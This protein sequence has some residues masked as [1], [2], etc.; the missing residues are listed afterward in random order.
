MLQFILSTL[1]IWVYS[2]TDSV[3][4]N[5]LAGASAAHI[6]TLYALRIGIADS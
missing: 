6:S 4:V 3:A 2:T 1:D 5:I